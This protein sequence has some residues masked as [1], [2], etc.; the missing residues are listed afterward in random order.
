[1]TLTRTVCQGTLDELAHLGLGK[2]GISAIPGLQQQ[3]YFQLEV[4][5]TSC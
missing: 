4:M 2:G 5:P 1:M 3:K